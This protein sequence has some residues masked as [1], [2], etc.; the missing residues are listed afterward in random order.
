MRKKLS[1][2][3][4]P[5]LKPFLILDQSISKQSIFKVALYGAAPSLIFLPLLDHFIW[6]N[7]GDILVSI[8]RAISVFWFFYLAFVLSRKFNFRRSKVFVFIFSFASMYILFLG[9]SFSIF[10]I[11]YTHLD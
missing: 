1:K 9:V 7:D 11:W 4:M 8:I 5:F 3:S 6:T 2:N 10:M